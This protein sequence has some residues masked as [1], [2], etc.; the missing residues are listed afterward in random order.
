MTT[1][2]LSQAD[3]RRTFQAQ[4]DGP[5]TVLHDEIRSDGI[6]IGAY[7][8]LADPTQREKA[9]GMDG[10]I[11][12]KTSGSP[13]FMQSWGRNK[14]VV[15]YLSRGSSD[16]GIEPLVLV[17]EF[18]GAA[19]STLELDQ[20]F[21]LFHNLHYD[22][23]SNTYMKMNDDGTQT[24]AVKFTG[25]RMAVRTFLLK[26]YIAARQIDLLLFIDSIV[27][28]SERA[29]MMATG[30]F[31]A[32]NFNAR[33]DYF[34]ARFSSSGDYGSRYCATKVIPPG[35]VETCG[36]WPYEEEDDHFPGFVIGED[37]H[38]RQVRFTCNPDLLANYFGKN[39][40]EPHYLTP[41]HFRR[42]VLAKYYDNPELYT[43][44][45]GYLRC[46]NLWGVQID[47][48][49]DD[50]GRGLPRRRGTGPAGL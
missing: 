29:E 31:A 14:E 49:H 21:R 19:E 34:K 10:W 22:P 13:G 7:C 2:D 37:D 1:H 18:Y 45:D 41:V 17:R 8:A 25:N 48:D 42:E 40:D 30:R 16:D 46:A 23:A 12:T 3:T 44:E 15:T 26:Q 5:W 24:L 33:L 32:A 38:G 6:S 35:P 50:R 43:V 39:P 11:L 27:Y 36:I 47:N 4:G 20:Q 9:L 28:S